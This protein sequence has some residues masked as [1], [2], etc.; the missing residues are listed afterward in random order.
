[1][2]FTLLRIDRQRSSVLFHDLLA[3]RQTEP[4]PLFL[5][6]EKRRKQLFPRLLRDAGPVVAD[7][8]PPLAVRRLIDPNFDGVALA[9]GLISVPHEVVQ[10]PPEPIPVAREL[11][12]RGDVDLQFAS[13]IFE[14]RRNEMLD[15][16]DELDGR[17]PVPVERGVVGKVPELLDDAVQIIDLPLDAIDF[18]ERLLVA[19]AT[20]NLRS[21]TQRV[22]D[23]W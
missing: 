13:R 14:I 19:S 9:A 1:V 15:L 5:G 22:A 4:T 8:D 23:R 18:F 12:R 10:D 2:T 20:S 7:D 16:T 11:D 3:E 17:K 6:R 21:N